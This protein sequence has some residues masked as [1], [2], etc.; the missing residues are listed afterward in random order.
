MSN[1]IRLLAVILPLL[2]TTQSLLAATVAVNIEDF[3]FNPQTVTVNIGDSVK[4]TNK[5][6][7][8]HTTTSDVTKWDS[9]NLAPGASFT[10]VFKGQ[11]V[12]KYHCAIHPGMTGTITVRSI[13][14]THIKIGKDI[15]TA[16]PSRL[17]IKLNL[18]GKDP[19]QVYLGSYLVN[20]Q[21]AC[22]DCHSCPTYTA[23]HDPYKGEPKQFNPKIYLAGGRAFGP[24]VSKNLTPDATGKPAGLTLAQFKTLLRT[25]K[26]PDVPTNILQ[27]MPWPVYGMM[28]DYDLE[29]IYAYLSSIPKAVTP[30]SSAC[31]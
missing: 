11:G 25:G 28:S 31:P 24:F 13:N 17:P 12:F 21:G 26:D 27:V 9:M 23:G 7:A 20:A 6:A 29:A 3:L 10:F 19:N 5:G 1:S 30:P 4:W 18:T 14:Q 16:L 22:A 15:I 8:P 2:L